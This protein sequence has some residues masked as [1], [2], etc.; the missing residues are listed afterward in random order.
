MAGRQ[1]RDLDTD[2]DNQSASTCLLVAFMS[3]RVQGPEHAILRAS[4]RSKSSKVL[5]TVK[6]RADRP[7]SRAEVPRRLKRL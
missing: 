1:S 7:I 6:V 5:Q 4:D 2:V 3:G